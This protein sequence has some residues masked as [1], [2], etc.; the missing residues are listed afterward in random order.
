M[1]SFVENLQSPTDGGVVTTLYGA[2]NTLV[3]GA[4]NELPE[5]HGVHAG[6]DIA[7]PVTNN[8]YSIANGIVVWTGIES[9]NGG[10]KVVIRHNYDTETYYSLYFH[11]ADFVVAVGEE[12]NKGTII[13]QMGN[14]GMGYNNPYDNIHLHFEVR[15]ETGV[16]PQDINKPF[17]YPGGLWWA[18]SSSSIL[19]NWVDISSRFGGYDPYLPDSWR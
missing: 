12:V 1:N 9:N 4:R 6:V 18:K 2:P 3:A 5:K 13:G 16:G 19:T 7:N 11:L 10:N 14:T 15:T 8:I 17:I